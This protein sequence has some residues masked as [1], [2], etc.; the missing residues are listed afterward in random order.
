MLEGDKA[1]AHGRQRISGFFFFIYAAFGTFVPYLTVF[2]KIKGMSNFQ[3]GAL[4]AANPI[5]ALVS[6]ML[7][8]LACDAI[9]DRRRPLALILVLSAFTFPALLL[10]DDFW[11]IMAL[12][13]IFNFFFRP[14]LSMGDAAALEFVEGHGADYGKLRMWGAI[15]FVL[16]LGLLSLLMGKEA[17]ENVA[18]DRLAP[19]F[20]GYF[21]FG[22]V[23]AAAAWRLPARRAAQFTNIFRWSILRQVLTPNIVLL[24]FCGSV[25]AAVMWTYYAFLPV[26][27]DELGVADSLKGL[28]WAIAV[29]PEVGF[30]YFAGAISRR[31]GKKWLF[32]I[33]ITASSIRLAIFASAESYWLVGLGQTLHPLSFA[34][35]Y[36]AMV[37]LVD[38]EVPGKLRTT[39]QTFA[40][41]IG[42]GLGGTVGLLVGGKVAGI[43]GITTLFAAGSVITLVVALVAAVF[44]KERRRGPG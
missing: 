29:V 16:P 15:G 9:G 6:P 13:V 18:A 7:W 11:S 38:G 24:V 25:H 26:R 14:S 39:G 10:A 4:Y 8:G 1:T 22:L 43:W 44:L 34:A 23:A 12:L 42:S 35:S 40:Y 2:F 31:I 20:A 3:V 30:F 21:I 17:G 33:G 32:V 28:F 19:M 41:G 36:I 5:V 37:T 27:L